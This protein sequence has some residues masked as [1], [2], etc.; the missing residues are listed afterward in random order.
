MP[1]GQRLAFPAMDTHLHAWDLSRAWGRPL[2]L[3]PDVIA[4]ARRSLSA[5]PDEMLRSP[6]T[7]GPALDPPADATPTESLMAFLGREPRR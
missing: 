7:F 6:Q 1:I 5:V 3:D 2:E 4:F